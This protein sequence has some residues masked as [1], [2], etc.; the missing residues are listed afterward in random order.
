MSSVWLTRYQAIARP[1]LRLVCFPYAGAGAAAFRPWAFALPGGVEMWAVELPARARR[2]AEA[3]VGDLRALADALAAAVRAA[4]PE[5]C[6]FF[7][8]SMGGLLAFEVCR[9]L[10]TAGAPLPRHLV[11][12]ARRAPQLPPRVEPIA[13]LSDA[14]FV[15]AI[16]DR[17]DG[18]PEMVLREPEL[19]S[20]FLPALRAD[21]SALE[22]Y[23]YE[24]APPL[25][26]P[27]TALVGRDDPNAPAE[28]VTPWREQTSKTFALHTLPGAH[29]FIN[30]HREAV[31]DLLRRTVL[32]G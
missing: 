27:I 1:E 7:G 24:P 26:I 17:Y 6:V 10:V 5:P 22:G 8:H 25:P 13:G 2:I 23:A 29:F 12:S 16:V 18:I 32:N 30:T 31:L 9:R 4:I 14:E 11:V 3:P 28:D 19:L 20:L 15:R 21:L